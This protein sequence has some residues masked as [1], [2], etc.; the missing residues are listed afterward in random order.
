[1]ARRFLFYML[2][3]IACVA[4]YRVHMIDN[5]LFDVGAFGNLKFIEIN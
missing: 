2:K 1:M 5:D 3:L 4:T